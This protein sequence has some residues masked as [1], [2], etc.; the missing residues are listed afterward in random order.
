MAKEAQ[1]I[2]S[3]LVSPTV[4]NALREFDSPTV[5]NAIE[6]FGVR[7]LT[8]GYASMELRCQF[9]DLEPM[10]GY[11]V[12][13]V[14]ESTRPGPKRPT[15]LHELFDV[16]AEAPKPAV[17]VIAH[18]DSDRPR[19]CVGG[20]MIFTAYRRLGVVGVVTDGG[21]RDLAGVRQRTPDLQ[22]FAPGTVVSHGTMTRI[23]MSVP[24]SVCG[25]TINPGDLLHGDQTGLVKVPV[26]I[27]EKI[28]ARAHEVRA[29]E[30]GMFRFLEGPDVSVDGLKEH[31]PA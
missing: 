25:M 26:D 20:D 6:A 29:E 4:L 9:P 1:L 18:V 5:S 15:G 22:V 7:D 3:A 28:V 23:D 21:V 24:V 12:T 27:A 8:E 17:V 11:A 14:A 16:L 13:C 10:V 2:M 19:S 31:F 30:E